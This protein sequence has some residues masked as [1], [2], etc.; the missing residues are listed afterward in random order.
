ML[1]APA[2]LVVT[3]LIL[4]TSKTP[5]VSAWAFVAGALLL[6][7]IIAALLYGLIELTGAN[8]SK[9][10]ALVLD[11]LLGGIFLYLGVSAFISHESPEEQRAKR[12]RIERLTSGGILS[13]FVVGVAVQIIN[14]DAL[15][16]F[17]G[18]IK[19]LALEKADPSA[20]VVAI[21][22]S[23]LIMLLPYYLPAVLYWISPG[24]AKKIL[25]PMNEWL[26]SHLRLLEIVVGL[27]FGIGFLSKGLSGLS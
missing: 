21:I 26:V 22:V 7:V 20:V 16:M 27:G 14:A 5:S 9:D 17:A 2:A 11:L 23:L 18:G 3:S 1:A 6:D 10:F 8:G 25:V 24:R 13:L 12:E 4:S 15:A 19:E